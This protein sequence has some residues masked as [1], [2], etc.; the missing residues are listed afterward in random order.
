MIEPFYKILDDAR[1]NLT[2]KVQPKSKRPGIQ[3][4]VISKLG[5]ALKIGVSEPA[6]DGK[7]NQA[8]VKILSK[9]LL[10]PSSNITIILGQTS[11]DKVVNIVGDIEELIVK[12]DTL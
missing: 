1:V 11:R 5:S 9:A 4:R 2:I 12:L 8:V 3:S 10:I 6:E 7:A